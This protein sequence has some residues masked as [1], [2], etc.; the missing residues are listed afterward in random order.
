MTVKPTMPIRVTQVVAAHIKLN[1]FT[2]TSIPAS[3]RCFY[4]TVPATATTARLIKCENPE[5][6]YQDLTDRGCPVKSSIAYTSASYYFFINPNRY[7][8][9]SH[10]CRFINFGV[11]NGVFGPQPFFDEG[12]QGLSYNDTLKRDHLDSIF[13]LLPD[14]QKR[15]RRFHFR[16]LYDKRGLHTEQFTLHYP[17]GHLRLSPTLCEGGRSTIGDLVPGARFFR[18][19]I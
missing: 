12:L 3:T 1:T 17:H 2:E 19:K 14:K 11:G 16:N 5:Q 13:L 7:F 10:S 6:K 15:E 4:Y 9:V 8:E 18:L